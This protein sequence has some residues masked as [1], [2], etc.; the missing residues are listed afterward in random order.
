MASTEHGSTTHLQR[1]A[2]SE[3]EE[4]SKR[5]RLSESTDPADTGS[6]SQEYTKARKTKRKAW[7]KTKNL[8]PFQ[9]VK[10]DDK[11]S[12]APSVTTGY[13]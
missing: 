8:K 2:R 11:D 1:K 12:K 5:R 10:G 7:K 9:Q 4:Q 3:N 13:R 6:S